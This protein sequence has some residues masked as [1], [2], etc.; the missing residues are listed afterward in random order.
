MQ[1]Q[2][3]TSFAPTSA[4]APR[5]IVFL[6]LDGF[7]QLDFACALEPLR[8]A[9][10][11]VD[12][13]VYDWCIATESGG[14]ARCSADLTLMA[15]SPL[16]R[17]ALSDRLA[18][19]GGVSSPE[20]EIDKV[21]GYVRRAAAHGRRIVGIGGGAH[22]LAK[23]GLLDGRNCAVHWRC[24]A[25]FAKQYPAVKVSTTAFVDA[26]LPTAAGGTSAADLTLHMIRQDHGPHVAQKVAD[27]M[28][29]RSVRETGG[30]QTSST[31]S[32]IGS[33]DAN[34]MKA[35]KAMESNIESPLNATELAAVAEVSVRQLERLF[36]RDLGTT[37][38][39]HYL[40]IRLDR[41]HELLQQTDLSVNEIAIAVGFCSTSRF[42]KCFRKAFG[43]PPLAKTA[44]RR[45]G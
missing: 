19:V 38:I 1:H 37:P 3:A 13:K 33:R 16:P 5:R 40:S 44:G 28:L 12:H 4:Q 20:A 31:L 29:H 34:L 43:M 23:A 11:V 39:R 6:L 24:A 41:A 8:L 26:T 45:K 14:A 2:P 15:H 18:I 42:Y 30:P 9:N 17:L 10:L 35:V 22:V 27:L 21:L 25:G 36:V 7:D 32:R